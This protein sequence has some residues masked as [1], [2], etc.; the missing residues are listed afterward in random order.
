MWGYLFWTSVEPL[1]QSLS[2]KFS[3]NSIFTYMQWSSLYIIHLHFS[4]IIMFF[5]PPLLLYLT[6]S[7]NWMGFSLLYSHP[8]SLLLYTKLFALQPKRNPPGLCNMIHC[9]FCNFSTVSFLVSDLF[10]FFSFYFLFIL[11]SFLQKMS[12]P[13]S[14]SSSLSINLFLGFTMKCRGA[15]IPQT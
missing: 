13:N 2:V 10:F 8:P 12:F 1:Q 14:N 6:T 15:C 9:P 11:F 3:I 4:F 7:G 5:W